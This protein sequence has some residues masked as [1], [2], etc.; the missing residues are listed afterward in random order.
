MAFKA[1]LANAPQA[2]TLST[3]VDAKGLAS[4]AYTVWRDIGDDIGASQVNIPTATT[5]QDC[6]MACDRDEACAAVYMTAADASTTSPN[7]SSCKAI[8]GHRMVSITLRSVTRVVTTRLA[9]AN[10]TATLALAA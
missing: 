10:V 7:L 1:L 2:S 8:Q 4:G 3:N 9:S 6:L 5:V